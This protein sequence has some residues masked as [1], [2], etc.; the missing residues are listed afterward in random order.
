VFPTGI[1]VYRWIPLTRF[2]RIRV[3]GGEETL[4]FIPSDTLF[5]ALVAIS[6][7][8]WGDRAPEAIGRAFEPGAEPPFL[9]TGAFPA[10]PRLRFFPRPADWTPGDGK[11]LKRLRW[12]SEGLFARIVK[13]EDLL[14]LF[15]SEDAA[16]AGERAL[17][18]IAPVRMLREERQRLPKLMREGRPS[19]WR[20]W[21]RDF[22]R[23]AVTVSRAGGRPALYFLTMV[24]YAPTVSWWVALAWG[25]RAEAPAW[26]GGPS[27]RTLVE[28]GLRMLG[29]HGVGGLRSRGGGAFR[30]VEDPEPLSVPVGPA[31]VVVTLARYHPRPEELAARV[32]AAPRAAYQLLQVG[33]WSAIP[34]RPD[35]PRRPIGM[36]EAGA[37]LAA[38]SRFPLGM[39]VDARLDPA[40]AARF[41]HPL[42][43]YGLAFPVPMAGEPG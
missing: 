34:G 30:M 20:L 1:T 8:R 26:P 13:G 31:P 18:K 33:G 21:E 14:D 32:L 15:P 19:A 41:P 36:I 3:S 42:W 24:R 17:A 22:Q 39:L 37:V 4:E 5:A 12:V 16:D 35:Q 7:L 10:L 43:R 40:D 9:L 25:E 38:G 11:S 23:P 2:L 27:F 28:E 6:A 29:E